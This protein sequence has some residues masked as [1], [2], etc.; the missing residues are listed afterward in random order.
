MSP[1]T[2]GV[3]NRMKE[4]AAQLGGE[5][6]AGKPFGFKLSFCFLCVTCCWLIMGSHALQ[7]FC[8]LALC[9]KYKTLKM[10]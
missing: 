6:A 7:E 10:G 3:E 4:S 2:K 8:S 9:S 1:A 5:L